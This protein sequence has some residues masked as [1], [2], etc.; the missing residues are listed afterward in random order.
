MPGQLPPG[1]SVLD[2]T[3]RR[4]LRHQIVNLRVLLILAQNL[5]Q[6]VHQQAVDFQVW[7]RLVL[8]DQSLDC[9][10]ILLLVEAAAPDVSRLLLGESGDPCG[11]EEIRVQTGANS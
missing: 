5:G 10:Q 3:F 4:K 9:I 6:L 1:A 11:D 7:D 2:L 8:A